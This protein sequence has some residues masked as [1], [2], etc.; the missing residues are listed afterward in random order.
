MFLDKYLICSCYF[1][2]HCCMMQKK[3]LLADAE[4]TR[5]SIEDIRAISDN[6]EELCERN[7]A[8]NSG[9]HSME[10]F[11]CRIFEISSFSFFF[12][13]HFPWSTILFGL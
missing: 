2:P 5:A 10:S 6:F 4:E 12:S 11:V 3:L 8:A 13:F 1:I 9:W 7:L